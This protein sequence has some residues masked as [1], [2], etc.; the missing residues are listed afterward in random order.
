MKTTLEVSITTPDRGILM[1]HKEINLPFAPHCDMTISDIA[2]K[3]EKKI[4]S[5]SLIIDPDSQEPSLYIRLESDNAKDADE[6][7]CLTKTYESCEWQS[8]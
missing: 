5:V 7:N 4:I 6:Q 2:W 3:N 8:I 1:V